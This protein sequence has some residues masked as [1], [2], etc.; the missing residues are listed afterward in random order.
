MTKSFLNIAF[1]SSVALML[2]PGC[3]TPNEIPPA[4]IVNLCEVHLQG[5]FTQTPVTVSVDNSRLFAGNVSTSAIL[6]VAA[7]IPVH[8]TKGTHALN[9]TVS[10]SISKDTTFTIADTLFI[11]VNYDS[12]T[13]HI[14]YYFTRHR[15][16]YD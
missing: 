3:N 14:T 8:V 12:R 2:Q 10:N 16:I 1:L 13:S 7:V 9:V 6:G 15:F 5:W 11:G 4:D